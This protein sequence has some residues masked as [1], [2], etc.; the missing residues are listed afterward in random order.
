MIVN[1]ENNILPRIIALCFLSALAAI[2]TDVAAVFGQSS[3]IASQPP[4]FTD[5]T[6]GQTFDDRGEPKTDWRE[7]APGVCFTDD[8]SALHKNCNAYFMQDLNYDYLCP[9]FDDSI[10]EKFPM[11][12]VNSRLVSGNY[13]EA[14]LNIQRVSFVLFGDDEVWYRMENFRDPRT[15]RYYLQARARALEFK[16]ETQKAL[17]L[18]Y[19]LYG[20]SSN[21]TALIHARL[22][23]SD[24]HT[25]SSDDFVEVC[26]ALKKHE[27]LDI[28]GIRDSME[29][30]LSKPYDKPKLTIIPAPDNAPFY[31]DA[32][33]LYT[34]RD[35]CAQIVNPKLHY[36]AE[37]SYHLIVES[38]KSYAIFLDMMEERYRSFAGTLGSSEGIAQKGMDVARGIMRL[39]F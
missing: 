7:F 18:Y 20:D 19:F 30:Y 25:L 1:Y 5:S 34:L 35:R 9:D 15:S 27:G 32:K 4:S 3:E 36:T 24:N 16:G 28:D 38:R 39:P 33:R 8:Y 31:I 37:D 22:N 26:R 14:L 11:N 2:L 6:N 29:I 12:R 13:D 21:E 23:Y 17:G 10:E